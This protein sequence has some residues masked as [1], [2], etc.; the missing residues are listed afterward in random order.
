MAKRPQFLDLYGKQFK[1]VKGDG[2][3]RKQ[4]DTLF[5]AY[6]RPSATK[7]HIWQAWLDWADCVASDNNDISIYITGRNPN[8][9][10]IGGYIH[11]PTDEHFAFY[12]TYTSQAI[13]SIDQQGER[14]REG[15]TP[16]PC[17]N[18]TGGKIKMKERNK[19]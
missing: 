11:T 3:P 4:Y 12:I 1:V 14:T 19:Q 6:D 2:I 18:R 10:S 16:S 8:F 9:F 7:V 17:F 13:W 5:E 15:S